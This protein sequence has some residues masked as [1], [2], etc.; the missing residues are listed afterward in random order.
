MGKVFHKHR[1]QLIP[2]CKRRFEYGTSEPLLQKIHA[3]K[4]KNIVFP[5]S[6]MAFWFLL[7]LTMITGWVGPLVLGGLI[8]ATDVLWVNVRHR[9]LRID[10]WSV[11]RSVV[12]SYPAF[13]YHC[14]SFASRYYLV[15]TLAVAIIW[16][17]GGIIIIAMHL[18][19][20][21]VEFRLKK[22][23]MNPL[24]FFMYFT[25]EQLSYQL[26]VWYGCIK[27]RC[28]MPVN[29]RVVSGLPVCDALKVPYL[30]THTFV[31]ELRP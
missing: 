19:A 11:C 17:T 31:E 26:G 28:L 18:L 12:R 24:V 13:L 23:A 4:V 30:K 7:L 2:F 25:L 21:T 6:K 16:P 22:P 15:F 8:V 29:P 14:C 5:P 9:H 3:G 27:Y 10:L 20:G 1:N